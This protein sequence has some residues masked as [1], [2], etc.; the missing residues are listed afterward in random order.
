MS[1]Y[2]PDPRP[3]VVSTEPINGGILANAASAVTITFGLDLDQTVDLSA[4]VK[5]LDTTDS[6]YVT[7][8]TVTYYTGKKEL[9][10]YGGW[11]YDD[12]N[13]TDFP[14]ATTQII[15]NQQDYPI[16][17]EALIVNDLEVKDSSGNWYDLKPITSEEIDKLQAEK[18]FFKTNGLPIY[19]LLISGSFKLF[20]TPNYTQAASLRISFDR[21][22]TTF[23]SGD[24]TKTPGFVSQFH[25]AVAVGMALEWARE[26]GL[27]DLLQGLYAD[28]RRYELDIKKFYTVRYYEKYPKRI[29]VLDVVRENM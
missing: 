7:S 8:L 29:K 23:T 1:A 12:S 26:K 11:I 27:N 28:W 2:T 6:T 9:E 20:P 3:Q 22:A 10:V 17:S 24:T 13:N 19:Y 15:S 4:Y 14:I 16:P 18:E 5:A 21:G 25:D